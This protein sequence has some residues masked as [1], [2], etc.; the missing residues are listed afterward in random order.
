[1]EEIIN[2]Y[3][4]EDGHI[5]NVT[6][7]KETQ[8]NKGEIIYEVLRVIDGKPV[9][10]DEH[11]ER[12]Q[13][14]FELVK[15]QFSYDKNKISEYIESLINANNVEVGNIK[16]TFN[17]E[18]DTLKAYFVKHSYP[19]NKM[20]KDGVK[21]ILYRGERENPN[22]K[23]IKNQFREQVNKEIKSNNAFEAMLVNNEGM[24]TEG[25]KSNLFFIKGDKVIT[26]NGEFVLKGI[27]RA[28]IIQCIEES[29]YTLEERLVSE[30]ELEEM[31][32]AFISGTSPK[33]LPIKECNGIEF[34]VN[35]IILRD[36]MSK[37]NEKIVES[38]K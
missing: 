1:M 21:T 10:L 7:Y 18:T 22:A 4:L 26:S 3:Y 8:D 38:Y 30:K 19:T 32:A 14:S 25:S 36:L 35:N 13:K 29:G 20:Y 5:D 12:M 2:E 11:I 23:I 15:I 9:F 27:T 16:I 34:D 37:Y 17:T 31:D 24:I 6:N 33:V 28:K